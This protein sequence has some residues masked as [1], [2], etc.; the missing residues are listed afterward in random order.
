M[1]SP[2]SAVSISVI[3]ANKAKYRSVQSSSPGLP[4]NWLT[5]QVCAVHI[6]LKCGAAVQPLGPMSGSRPWPVGSRF[7]TLAEAV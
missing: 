2:N 6:G 5:A 3:T 1:R 7:V 4:P